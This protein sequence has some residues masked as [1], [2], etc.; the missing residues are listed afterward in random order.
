MTI[1]HGELW[2]VL[3]PRGGLLGTPQKSQVLAWEN[4]LRVPPH[5][6]MDAFYGKGQVSRCEAQ[7][8]RCVRV[9]LREEVK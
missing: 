8:M 2:V 6:S 9:E 1:K 4:A 3:G 5:M 7:G